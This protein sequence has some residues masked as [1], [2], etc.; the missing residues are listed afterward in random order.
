MRKFTLSL[1]FSLLMLVI[2][3]VASAQ[4]VG[5]MA[6]NVSGWELWFSSLTTSD[7]HGLAP[8]LGY[9]KSRPNSQYNSC[10]SHL[11]DPGFYFDFPKL[12]TAGHAN[13][14][15]KRLDTVGDLST[16]VSMS[17]RLVMTSNNGSP[18]ID[19]G[20]GQGGNTCVVPANTRIFFWQTGGVNTG[21]DRW[22]SNASVVQL[23]PGDV[24]ISTSFDTSLWSS[25]FGHVANEDST[26]TANFLA[27]LAQSEF[28]GMT[29]GGGCFAGHGVSVDDVQSG[30]ESDTFR[31]TVMDYHISY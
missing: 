11:K 24:T 20:Y 28:V 8:T 14:L 23:A 2:G 5:N 9:C 29:L 16:A 10:I 13:Y 30:H 21:N 17:M 25:T 18:I 1:V 31:F 12:S 19:Y 22:W 3:T 6:G 4:T 15:V 26:W 7:L 27:A